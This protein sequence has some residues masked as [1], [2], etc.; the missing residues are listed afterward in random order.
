MPQVEVGGVALRY[1]ERGRGA[2]VV[3]TPG[4]RWGGYV[5]RVVATELAKDFRVIT[6]DRPNTDGASDVV[7]RGS[8]SEADVWA[9]LLAGLIEKLGLAPCHVGEYAGCRTTP[10]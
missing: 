10:L 4:G 2:P 1:E 9:S 8:E 7:R 6:W 3:L 5:M